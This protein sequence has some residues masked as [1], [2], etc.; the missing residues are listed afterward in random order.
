MN[1]HKSATHNRVEIYEYQKDTT[2]I[3]TFKGQQSLNF[4]KHHQSAE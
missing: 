1:N 3:I 4:K 2:E